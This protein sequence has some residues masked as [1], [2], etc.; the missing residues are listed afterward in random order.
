MKKRNFKMLISFL[1]G[2]IAVLLTYSAV[3]AAGNSPCGT[4]KCWTFDAGYEIAFLS[5]SVE[6]GYE[7]WTYTV[8]RTKKN[9]SAQALYIGIEKEL[10]LDMS[11]T[12]ADENTIE[13]CQQDSSTNIN[14]CL[15]R[16]LKWTPSNSSLP[17]EIFFTVQSTGKETTAPAFVK[18]SSG[19]EAGAIVGPAVDK[20]GVLETTILFAESVDHDSLAVIVDREGNIKE[21]WYCDHDEDMDNDPNTATDCAATNFPSSTSFKLLDDTNTLEFDQQYYCVET[22]GTAFDQ[23]ATLTFTGD[24]GTSVHCGPIQFLDEKT[25]FKFENATICHQVG[26]RSV[27]KTY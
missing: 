19:I 7:T 26:G 10:V 2:A 12:N 4:N 16:Y 6:N 18:D 23:N 22:E 8:T 5:K 13:P 17:V 3:L 25:K 15:R 1:I 24:T 20:T 11:S 9:T 21:S 14:D 27:C